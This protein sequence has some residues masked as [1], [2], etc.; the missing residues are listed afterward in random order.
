[1]ASGFAFLKLSFAFVSLLLIA[2]GGILFKRSIWPKRR[3]TE[4]QC[5]GCGYS[6]IGLASER[7]PE[8]GALLSPATIV[9]G[10]RDRRVGLGLIGLAILMLGLIVPVTVIVEEISDVQWYHLK[11]AFMVMRDL[12]LGSGTVADEAIVELDR[13]DVAGELSSDYQ[14]QI[15]AMALAQQATSSQTIVTSD[16][17]QFLERQFTAGRL[18]DAQKALFGQ[19]C[20]TLSLRIRPTTVAGGWVPFLIDEKCR[21]INPPMYVHLEDADKVEIDG[22]TVSQGSSGSGSMSGL[23]SSGSSGNSVK[24]PPPGRHTLRVSSHVEVRGGSFGGTDPR[25]ILFQEERVLTGTFEVVAQ[26]PPGDLTIIN[27]PKLTAPIRAS[28]TPANFAIG[29]LDAKSLQGHLKMAWVPANLAFDVFIRCG[30]RT[31]QVGSIT[32][33]KGSNGDWMI[34]GPVSGIP[35]SSNFDLILRSSE[36]AARNTTDMHDFWNGELIYPGIPITVDPS[37]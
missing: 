8:C 10:R 2:I 23:G 7:C 11:P 33:N 25:Q 22:V 3:G 17:L 27:D 35:Q 28:I 37:R 9:L 30:G 26:P 12:R 5:R 36:K 24:A 34:G 18:T 21:V 19:Q 16:L 29:K 20:V 4:P 31:T 6:L 1:M 15:V 14:Q 32:V 13:R